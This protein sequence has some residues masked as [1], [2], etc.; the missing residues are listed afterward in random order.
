MKEIYISLLNCKNRLIQ[1]EPTASMFL[2]L[3]GEDRVTKKNLPAYSE[4]AKGSRVIDIITSNG[5]LAP[6]YAFIKNAR[7]QP[8]FYQLQNIK[9]H[10]KSSF[11]SIYKTADMRQIRETCPFNIYG[12]I[13]YKSKKKVQHTTTHF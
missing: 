1:M 5:E 12:R 8:V 9:N 4:W 11:M 3:F 2:P 6:N 13:V 10:L 7:R